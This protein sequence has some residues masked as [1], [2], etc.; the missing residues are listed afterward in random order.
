MVWS[1]RIDCW[2]EKP[3][4]LVGGDGTMAYT[5]GY[6]PSSQTRLFVMESIGSGSHRYQ[7][8]YNLVM[9]P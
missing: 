2:I 1:C 5:I 6:N 9:F 4:E 8:F 3:Q 7:M